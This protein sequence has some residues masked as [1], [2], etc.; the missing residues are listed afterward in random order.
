[1]TPDMPYWD[2]LCYLYQC[3]KENGNV[4]L[5]QTTTAFNSDNQQIQFKKKLRTTIMQK[6]I[7]LGY[8]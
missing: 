8:I 2:A 5:E 3:L 1:M 7:S 6:E 4:K